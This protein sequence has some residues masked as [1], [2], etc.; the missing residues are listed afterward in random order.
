MTQKTCGVG[1]QSPRRMFFTVAMCSRK[2]ISR[3]QARGGAL[4]SVRHPSR[5]LRKSFL[6]CIATK[7][8]RAC[9]REEGALRLVRH[10]SWPLRKSFL[11]CIVATGFRACGREEGLCDRPSTLRSL[12][13]N[14]SVLYCGNR[15]S[16]LRARGG[17][18]AIGP[19]PL[20]SPSGCYMS[21]ITGK[22]NGMQM[23][24]SSELSPGLI[25][26]RRADLAVG[27]RTDC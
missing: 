12:F 16:C 14:L 26:V 10:P 8:F 27:R 17:G 2:R 15:I 24:P 7:G 23:R 20:R 3:L 1:A 22:N 5:P 13:V 25:A 18:F 11:L 21:G 6:F 19:P 4:R 9:G